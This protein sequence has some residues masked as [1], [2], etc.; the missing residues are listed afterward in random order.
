MALILPVI[1]QANW[2]TT[3]N[4]ALV[5]LESI[6][7]SG[8]GGVAL[9]GTPTTGQVPT[10][11]SPT[12]AT[13][14]TPS[15]SS[16]PT[17]PAG[18]AL[19][20]N[21]P[22]PTLAVTGVTAGTY[23]S[24]ANVATFAVNAEGQLTSVSN[25][26]IAIPQSAVTGLSTALALL[27]PLASPAFTGVPTAPTA[28]P[29]TNTTQVATTAF[30]EAA[31]PSSLPPTG[32]AG[33]SLAGTYPNPT[34][35]AT[36]V[37]AG[38]YGS[39][40][41]VPTVTYNAA[42]QA[43]AASNT[44]IQITESA[45]TGLSTSLAALAPLASPALTGTPTAPTA[46]GG[47]NTTQLA[48]TAFVTAAV[49]TTLEQLT[50]Y[51]S[52]SDTRYVQQANLDTSIIYEPSLKLQRY[53]QPTAIV[54]DFQSGHG[55]T[56]S[57]G[58]FTANDTSTYVRGTQ[59]MTL[60]T[61]GDSNFYSITGTVSSFDM[62]A[63]I[64]RVT[65]QV[66]TSATLNSLLIDLATDS[67]FTNGWTWQMQG[68]FS[69]SEYF[70][71]GDW[72]TQGLSFHT[73]TKI[74]SGA[75]TALTAAR[76]R[77]QDSGTPVTVHFQEIDIIADG[78]ATFPN[79][80]VS[81][82]FDDSYQDALDLGKTKLDQYGY[83]ATTFT[84]ADLIGTSGRLTLQELIN[85]QSNNGW[86]VACHAY[87][88]VVHGET[89][90]GVTAAV[91]DADVRALKAFAVEN[92]FRGA[93]LLAYPKGQ[94]G[95]TTDNV[96]TTSI[97]QKYFS[98]GLSTINKTKSP[99]PPSDPWRIQRISG[100]SSFAGSYLPSTITTPTTGDLALCKANS[101]WTI[102]SFHEIVTTT[103]TAA[104]Q[105]LQSD[106]N[107]I[108]DTIN[109]L[110]IPVLP[111]S[112]VIRWASTNATAAATIDITDIPK[113]LGVVGATGSGPLAAPW[114]HV[115]PRQSWAPEDHN[116]VTWSYDPSVAGS[117]SAPSSAGVLNLARV[118]VPVASSATNVIL[119]ITTVGSTLTSGQNFAGLYNSAGNLVATTA[120]QTT[121]WGTTGSK[122]MALT[123]GPF[124][125][126]AGDYYVGWFATGTTAPS[127][128]RGVSQ[129]VA[130]IG[131]TSSTARY[132]TGATGTT[133]M[134]ATTGTLTG[135]SNAWWVGIS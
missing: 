96:S 65:A 19:A 80:V 61:P 40:S 88:D 58:T 128:L 90:T 5:Y 23:G 53:P 77:V 31:V 95:K 79:G 112:E 16:S 25:V 130:N 98:V 76:F 135:A 18:G 12:T 107:T 1:G 85:L 56:A 93:D 27:A 99:F 104:T 13:W 123:G 11:T 89:Y 64:P 91:M 21:Y 122:I 84:I 109:S 114:D 83:P 41:T 66:V 26:T 9:T 70:T 57:G 75:R 35:A 72:A 45:V 124:A 105:I 48:T 78:S 82:T 38:S 133:A 30:V 131:L 118:H 4:N 102:L 28:S 24:A 116:L 111:V 101:S 74:G 71:D 7:D 39:A 44:A 55:F 100:I 125:L 42:G 62:T 69:N 126:T 134:P 115:H 86:E 68:S 97:A 54:S 59:C 3:L 120:D 52:S 110:G 63:K 127:F 17:G 117:G 92:G 22:D 87:S 20:G 132:S 47:T 73:A 14:Q 60:T 10:A 67:T 37:T 46:T 33:G 50:D 103:P 129:S 81:I 113:K 94:F 36:T 108:I 106:F 34:L 2:A 43:T 6:A 8:L 121:N 29:G 119:F 49:P 32:S 15:G 51:P